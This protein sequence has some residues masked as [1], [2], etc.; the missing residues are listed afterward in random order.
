MSIFRFYH[1]QLKLAKLMLDSLLLAC[2]PALV[3]CPIESML[4]LFGLYRSGLVYHTAHP[5]WIQTHF[6]RH[7]CFKVTIRLNVYNFSAILDPLSIINSYIRTD[8]V[9][10]RFWNKF[11]L[12]YCGN[13][14]SE[15]RIKCK[16]CFNGTIFETAYVALRWL[17][18]VSWKVENTCFGPKIAYIDIL[19]EEWN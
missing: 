17:H 4:F 2:T 3:P 19:L 7:A 10:F 16:L 6:K 12:E 1:R 15:T 13:G 9:C 18:T 5:F 8:D 14:T 11:K